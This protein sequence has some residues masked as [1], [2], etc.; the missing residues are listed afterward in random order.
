VTI[1]VQSFTTTPNNPFYGPFHL[2]TD[3]DQST[4]WI[5]L[6]TADGRNSITI[7][8]SPLDAIPKL[9][10]EL[11]CYVPLHKIWYGIKS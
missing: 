7:P 3:N 11:F 4:P 2:E 10:S 1:K 6:H 9:A 5:T 8:E